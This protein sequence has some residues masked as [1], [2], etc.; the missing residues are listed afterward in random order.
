MPAAFL[1]NHE[2]A[3]SLHSKRN[4]GLPVQSKRIIMKNEGGGGVG[5]AGELSEVV[6][7]KKSRGRC[8]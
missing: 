8:V 7:R 6:W 2:V 1:R 5:K 4:L 3:G